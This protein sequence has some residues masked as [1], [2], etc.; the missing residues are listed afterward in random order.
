MR[1]HTAHQ[2]DI[3]L[4]QVAASLMQYTAIYQRTT[5][6]PGKSSTH[7]IRWGVT[8][9]LQ[10]FKKK[11]ADLTN[12]SFYGTIW[13]IA[14]DI[15]IGS[16]ITT[17]LRENETYL[18]DVITAILRVGIPRSISTCCTKLTRESSIQEYTIRR[19]QNLLLWLNDWPGGLKLNYELGKLFCDAFLWFTNAWEISILDRILF[20][21]LP[22]IIRL[23]S[24]S[25]M[26]GTTMAVSMACDLL[27]LATLHLYAFYV[28]STA[29]FGFHIKTM[30]SLFRT[31]RGELM[32][33]VR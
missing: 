11:W 5:I 18:T 2:A 10:R 30:A 8:H 25:A 32:V 21:S 9:L 26:L 6:D 17:F 13:L 24:T 4:R 33:G 23:I 22:F 29:I 3:R 14:N 15:I 19:L 7:Y 16:A 20:P 27:S 28:M 12:I 1:Y 31:F